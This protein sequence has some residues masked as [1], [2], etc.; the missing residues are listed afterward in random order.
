MFISL[1]KKLSEDGDVSCSKHLFTF[2]RLN[3]KLNTVMFKASA[4]I[5]TSLN[6]T[7]S[8]DSDVS[9]SKHL[10]TFSRLNKKLNTVLCS[11]RLLA[12]FASC[13]SNVH[14]FE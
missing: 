7:V 14:K 1:N 9:C 8:E 2:S 3:K 10:F 13:G 12:F 6:K 11:K 5:F 4:R